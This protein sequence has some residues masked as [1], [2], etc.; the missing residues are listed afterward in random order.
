MTVRDSSGSAPTAQHKR[1]CRAKTTEQFVVSATAVHGNRYGYELVDYSN[2]YTKI[3]IICKDH[4]VFDQSPACHLSGRGCLKCS[5]LNNLTTEGFIGRAVAVHG[6]NYDYSQVDYKNIRAKVK[7]TCKKHGAFEQVSKSH[8]R[9]HG[10]PKCHTRGFRRSSYIDMS[11]SHHGGFSNIY[12]IELS[13]KKERFFKV[14]I[15]VK[16]VA[17]RFNGKMAMPY[18]LKQIKCVRSGAEFIF[19]LENRLHSLLADHRYKPR[20]AFKG[21]G[22][23]FN[24]IPSAVLKLLDKIECTDQ[25]QL[26]A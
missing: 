24:H 21:D 6:E 13:N 15:T 19:D 4:G 2:S 20:V 26:I 5:G 23:C 10:C 3:K 11:I 12:V 18:N 9:G 7:I 1:D 16:S 8:L 22:E 25:M 14:G 17:E